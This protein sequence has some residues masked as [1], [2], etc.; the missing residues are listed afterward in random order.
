MSGRTVGKV[1]CRQWGRLIVVDNLAKHVHFEASAYT[2]LNAKTPQNAWT[3]F[4][5]IRL[6][7]V[8]YR[9]SDKSGD[10]TIFPLALGLG[11]V[12]GRTPRWPSVPLNS[13]APRA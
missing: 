8:G 7:R 1:N 10:A 2:R 11:L 12:Q 13:S 4:G 3:L 5:Q 9:P 6:W